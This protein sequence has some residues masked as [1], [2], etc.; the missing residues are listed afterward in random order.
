MYCYCEEK[1]KYGPLSKH[2]FQRTQQYGIWK[3][4]QSPDKPSWKMISSS[5][6]IKE[7]IFIKASYTN[8][9][10]TGEKF[11][12]CCYIWMFMSRFF[13]EK[14]QENALYFGLHESSFYFKLDKV[15][16]LQRVVYFHMPKGVFVWKNKS[17]KWWLGF[18]LFLWWRIKRFGYKF[19]APLKHISA[20]FSE[21]N[22]NI[23]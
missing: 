22:Q 14:A 2:F 15:R 17:L 19:V 3:S 10:R 20:F 5:Y 18:R 11:Y 9:I 8:N 23:L 7:K 21:T 16:F 4:S 6:H 12:C 1:V 13:S